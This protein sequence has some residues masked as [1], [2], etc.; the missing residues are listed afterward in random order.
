MLR[1]ED[2]VDSVE[3]NKMGGNKMCK[4]TY[5][6]SSHYSTMVLWRAAQT[7]IDQ[8]STPDFDASGELR[9]SPTESDT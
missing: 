6:G 1:D 3:T 8:R 9:R 7:I 2:I 5:V 4:N